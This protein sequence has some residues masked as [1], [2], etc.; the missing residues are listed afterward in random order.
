MRTPIL[1]ALL[2]T[3]SPLVALTPT[4]SAS[5]LI[6]G[7]VNGF[8]SIQDAIDA[9]QPGDT[10]FVS[11]GVYQESVLITT[12]DITLTG[13]SREGTVIDGGLQLQDGVTV[14]AD[15][16]TVKTM[17]ARNYVGNGF[18]FSHVDRFLLTDLHA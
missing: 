9:A 13:E 15:G 5:T 2:L 17:T 14:I 12:P 10:V 1:V 4:A 11:D 18:I 7:G 3:L 6:V 8:E 16:V